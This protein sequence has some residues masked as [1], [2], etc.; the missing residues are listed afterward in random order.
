MFMCEW[1][2]MHIFI[3]RA[4]C[5]FEKTVQRFNEL[6]VCVCARA[7]SRHCVSFDAKPRTGKIFNEF[8]LL[9]LFVGNVYWFRLQ[10]ALFSISHS[11]HHAIK[12]IKRESIGSDLK[13]YIGLASAQ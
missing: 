10:L 5:A 4:H 2:L 12:L 1:N 13:I 8:D 6:R 7:R 11:A 9:L 3:L